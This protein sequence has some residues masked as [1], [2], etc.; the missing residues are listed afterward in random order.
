VE[1]FEQALAALALLP[2][3]RDT[4]EQAIDLRCDLRNTLW[5]LGE[6]G[7]VFDYLCQ[8]EALAAALGDQGRLG[9]VSTYMTAY[10]W[11][12]G[13]PDRSLESGRRALTIAE[14]LGDV[15]L[16]VEANYRLGQAYLALGD[17]RRAM[18]FLGRNV[19]SLK[20][21][22]LHE[23]F[24]LP[25]IASVVSRSYLAWCLAELGE[26]VEAIARGEEAGAP[27]GAMV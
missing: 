24:G 3:R 2:E 9:R 14:A 8:A 21:H 23:R 20:G 18:E 11:V 19:S 26:F 12:M 7:Q 15:A 4:L 10:L 22:L 16:Q 13:H 1:G 6:F 25:G 17:Y 5:L 27:R